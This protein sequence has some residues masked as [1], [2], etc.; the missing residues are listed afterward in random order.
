MKKWTWL[1]AFMLPVIAQAQINCPAFGRLQN[2]E[3]FEVLL[4]WNTV[5]PFSSLADIY[6][7]EDHDPKQLGGEYENKSIA[8]GITFNYY[9]DDITVLRLKLIYTKRNIHSRVDLAD[10]LGNFFVDDRQYDQQIFKIAPGF[11]WTYI[12]ER[13]SFYGGFELPFTFQQDFVRTGYSLDSSTV[14]ETRI[15]NNSTLTIPPGYSIGIG[16]FAGSTFY[17]PRL[18][19]IGFEVSS[20]YQYSKLGGVIKTH[21]VT[22][23]TPLQIVDSEFTDESTFYKFSPLQASLHLSIRF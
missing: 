14:N 8:P 13:F 4:T 10:S 21:S 19:G 20:A 3:K 1:F 22:T 5:D 11:Q 6:L 12:V 23:D 15:E 17:F 16:C 7:N 2:Y 9:A 18:F